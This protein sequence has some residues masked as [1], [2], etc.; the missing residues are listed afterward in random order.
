M[1]TSKEVWI[2]AEQRNGR[3]MDVSVEL[4]GKAMELAR[5]IDGDSAA[6]LVGEEVDELAEELISYGVDKVYLITDPR[7]K[8]YQSG[9]YTKAISDLVEEHRPE[10]MLLG[11]TAIGMEL[12]PS[13]AAQVKTGLTA[14]CCELCIED[15]D[16][17]PKLVASVPG[18]GG[19]I[20]VKIVCPKRFP[21]MATVSA[22]V[23]EKPCTCD[24]PS[25]EII[26]LE[27]DL[28]DVDM[29]ARTVEMVENPPAGLPLEKADIVVAGG[30]GMKA[31]GDFASLKE[32]ASCLDAAVGGTRRAL[33]EGWIPE[34]NLIGTNG[35]TIS[36]KLLLSFGASGAN[37]W[38]AGFT[39]AETVVAVNKNEEAPVFKV[40]D[41]GIVADVC[42][43]IPCFL[44]AL[45]EEKGETN[46]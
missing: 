31:I 12:A 17:E 22:G 29:R 37:H 9:A 4:L 16:E 42:D 6:V 36:P 34:S 3:L 46:G 32:L 10:I 28:R 2:W 14:H 45:K 5:K 15:W 8:L 1:S 30:Y 24:N 38:V 19:S 18:F 20:R 39:R 21:Q 25:G 44:R 40:C 13:I 26:R 23:A 7:L 41:F 43:V 27:A 33:E 11:A 35:K